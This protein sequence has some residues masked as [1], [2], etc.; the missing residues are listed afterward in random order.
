MHPEQYARSKSCSLTYDCQFETM[1]DK[2]SSSKAAMRCRTAS[3]SADQP[4]HLQLPPRLCELESCVLDICLLVCLL[5][6][7]MPSSLIK[8]ICSE[9]ASDALLPAGTWAQTCQ[10]DACRYL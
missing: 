8:V 4:P 5:V 6:F 2:L 3:H 1:P 7:R 10:R 9:P